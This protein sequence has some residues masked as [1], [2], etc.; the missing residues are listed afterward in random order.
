MINCRTTRTTIPKDTGTINFN[1]VPII[2]IKNQVLKFFQWVLKSPL[3][4]NG[5]E[6]S[7]VRTSPF[8]N[9]C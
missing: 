9:L 4:K 6:E 2:K 3:S 8:A 1:K 5:W 7:Q